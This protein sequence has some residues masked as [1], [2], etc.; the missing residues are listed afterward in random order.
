MDL[1]VLAG[2][3]RATAADPEPA[4]EAAEAGYRAA[5]DA[6]VLDRLRGIEGRGRYR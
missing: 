5:G 1:H 4:V 6:A 2:S 3:V